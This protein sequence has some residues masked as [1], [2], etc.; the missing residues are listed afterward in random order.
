MIKDKGTNKEIKTMNT[1]QIIW[2]QISISTKMACG[3]RKAVAREDGL[4]FQV[5]AARPLTKIVVT[6][7][8]AD[9]Y[10]VQL[11]K[12]NL[13]SKTPVTILEETEG[14]FFDRLSETIYSMVNK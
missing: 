14:I 10:N 3:A 9:R 6:L 1:A 13:R 11:V 7:T 5:G 12:I 4:H 8:A 2:S